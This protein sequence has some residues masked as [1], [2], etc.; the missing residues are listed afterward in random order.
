MSVPRFTRARC[1]RRPV[2]PVAIDDVV[3][4]YAKACSAAVGQTVAEWLNNAARTAAQ[5][6]NAQAYLT[7]EAGNAGDMDDLDQA[8]ARTSLAGADW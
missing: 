6:Q 5:R 1:C 8:T 7:R 3:Y 2:V 4:Q